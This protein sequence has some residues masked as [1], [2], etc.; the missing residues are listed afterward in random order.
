[1][2]DALVVLLLS[3]AA[4]SWVVSQ[5]MIAFGLTARPPRWR[6]AVAVVLPPLGLYW[7]FR[8]RLRI[9][10]VVNVVAAI[11]YFVALLLARR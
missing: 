2:R 9:R 4:A 10:A 6:G 11:T 1:M 7:A 5:L 8:E 3:T